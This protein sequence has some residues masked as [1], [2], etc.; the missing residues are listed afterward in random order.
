[1]PYN[2]G[3]KV[4]LGCEWCRRIMKRDS[5]VEISR[6]KWSEVEASRQKWSEAEISREKCSSRDF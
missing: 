3:L 6:E 4:A 5:E 2:V 1:M